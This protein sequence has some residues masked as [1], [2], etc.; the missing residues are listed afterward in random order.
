LGG[1]LWRTGRVDEA[2]SVLESAAQ[3]HPADADIRHNLAVVLESIGRLDDAEREY[4]RAIAVHPAYAEAHNHLGNTL[5]AQGRVCEAVASHKRALALR[6]HDVSAL[7][8]LGTAQLELGDAEAA[9]ACYRGAVELRPVGPG[10]AAAHSSL[11][12][13]FHYLDGLTAADIFDE[14]LAWARR[15]A[16]PLRA[17]RPH[18]NGRDPERRLRVGYV[19]AD[20][21]EHPVARFQEAAL[22]YRN[23]SAVE[24]FCYSDVVRPD[25]ATRRLRG[26]ADVWRD[27]AGLTDTGLAELVG[28]D[29]IDVLVDL[30]GHA[31]GNRLLAFA[32]HPAPVQVTCNGYIDTTGMDAMDWRL[33]D[34]WHDPPDDCRFHS[35]EQL[36]RMPAGCW[37]YTPEHDAPEVSDLPARRNGRITFGCLNKLAKLSASAA[38]LWAEVLSAVPGSRLLLA[39]PAGA[40]EQ[41]EV[42]SRLARLGLPVSRVEIAG[43]ASTRQAYLARFAEIDLCLDPVPF[44]GITTTC[45]SLWMGVPVITLAGQVFAARAGVS[46]L[47]SAGLGTCVTSTPRE[48]IRIATLLAGEISTLAGLRRRLRDQVRSSALLDGP[49]FARKWESAIRAM[50]QA[51][52]GGS[53]PTSE[54]G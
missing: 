1:L 40:S 20:W 8:G 12:Y 38:R 51:W 54:D 36:Y 22:A 34:D 37:C 49:A 27:T 7:R 32:R 52:S 19:S 24:V 2:K 9:V 18:R 35:S 28:R 50:W 31:A 47:T 48:Y 21:R 17:W 3:T 30:T 53:R 16:D 23:S 5:R 46:L 43:R 10:A 45:D 13:T 26:M 4:R 11:L 15:H 6:P 41:R 39:G 44:N 25:A 29:G 14:H 33:S 42:L